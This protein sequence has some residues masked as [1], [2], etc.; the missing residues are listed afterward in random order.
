MTV[1]QAM[2]LAGIFTLLLVASGCILLADWGRPFEY[3]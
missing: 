3:G 1:L 2:D